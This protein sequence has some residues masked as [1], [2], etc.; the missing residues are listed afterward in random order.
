MQ[1]DALEQTSA[2]LTP[3]EIRQDELERYRKLSAEARE[4]NWLV[5]S[6]RKILIHKHA[7]GLPVEAGPLDLDVTESEQ[8][9]LT[10]EELIRILGLQVVEEVRTQIKPTVSKTVKVVDR[11]VKPSG[12]T[13]RRN[14][15]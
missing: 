5:E 8:R 11:P 7:Q 10:N 14:V 9:R 13:R 1:Q 2:E 6:L 12:R 15:A 4:L 3:V